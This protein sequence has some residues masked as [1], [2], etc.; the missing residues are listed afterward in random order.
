MRIIIIECDGGVEEAPRFVKLIGLACKPCGSS[1]YAPELLRATQAKCLIA[2][3]P[4]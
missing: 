1:F 3:N 2:T 4:A